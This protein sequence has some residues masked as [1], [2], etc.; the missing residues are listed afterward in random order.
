MG[1]AKCRHW[2][3]NERVTGGLHLHQLLRRYNGSRRLLLVR[4]SQIMFSGILA[5]LQQLEVSGNHRN[6]RSSGEKL[7][8]LSP[9][10]TKFT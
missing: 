9:Y 1:R 10:A 8:L 2:E 4:H 6:W 7:Y 5:L 3:V